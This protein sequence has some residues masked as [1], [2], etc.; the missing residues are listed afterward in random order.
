L[1]EQ[2]VIS[3]HPPTEKIL[4]KIDTRY[5]TSFLNKMFIFIIQA[6]TVVQNEGT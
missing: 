2:V 4:Y 6:S 5:C 3:Y 1:K